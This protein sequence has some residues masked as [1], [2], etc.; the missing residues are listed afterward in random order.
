MKL[1]VDVQTSPAV[2]VTASLA[3]GLQMDAELRLVG[4]VSQPAMLGRLNLDGGK[5]TFFGSSLYG[6]YRLHFVYQ[7]GPHRADAEPSLETESKG[8]DVVAECHRAAG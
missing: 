8:V 4:T 3:E 2:R 5:L 6:E 7:P 1:D